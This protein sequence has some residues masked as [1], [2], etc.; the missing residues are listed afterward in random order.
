MQ[1]FF[2]KKLMNLVNITS[3]FW[4][5]FQAFTCEELHQSM[6]HGSTW[7]SLFNS[8]EIFLSLILKTFYKWKMHC[9]TKNFV[10]LKSWCRRTELTSSAKRIFLIKNEKCFWFANC[11]LPS[12]DSN[13]SSI[14]KVAGFAKMLSMPPP[15]SLVTSQRK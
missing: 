15:P 9:I 5:G 4:S 2:G 11:Q 12:K 8:W 3:V 7:F 14:T 13:L 1:L 10:N 6:N